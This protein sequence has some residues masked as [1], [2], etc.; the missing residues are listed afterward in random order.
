MNKAIKKLAKDISSCSYDYD[1][2]IQECKDGIVKA[3]DYIAD[4][5][6]FLNEFLHRYNKASK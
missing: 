4:F 2:A 1:K 3:Y 6:I 5:C